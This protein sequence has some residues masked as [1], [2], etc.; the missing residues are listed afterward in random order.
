MERYEFSPANAADIPEIVSLYHSLVGTLGCTWDEDYPS[1]A[2]AESDLEQNTLYIL[3]ANGKIAAV[4]SLGAF[5]ELEDLPWAPKNPCELMR[6]GVAPTLQ[7]R[8]IGTVMLRKMMAL[9]KEKGFDG[10]R[11]LVSKHNAAALALY[12]KN[13]FEKCGEAFRFD[14]DFYCYQIK[15][16]PET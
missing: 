16:D 6:I 12:A 11:L 7:N 9:A 15:F 4:A 8:G 13:G 14:I 1:I 3:R 10:I 5:N 2:T